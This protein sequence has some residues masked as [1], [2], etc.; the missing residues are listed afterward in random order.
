MQRFVKPKKTLL[1]ANGEKPSLA[2]L[3]H[4][5]KYASKLIA[6]DGASSWLLEHGIKP[7]LIIGDMDSAD[8]NTIRGLPLLT[9]PDQ[10]SNDLE[11]GLS[12]CHELGYSEVTVL[13]AFGLRI[14]HFL[15]NLYVLKKWARLLT[16]TLVDEYQCGFLCDNQRQLEFI[17]LA[18]N[19]ISFFPLSD[20]VGPVWS[21]GVDYPLTNEMLSMSFRI[22]TLNRICSIKATLYCQNGDLFVT[23][24]N[25]MSD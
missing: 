4:Y 14:D 15:T 19:F 3:E 23:M 24:P 18:G 20:M 12:Y 6:L 16:V 1:I 22:G 25:V 7:D 17:N 9:V 13:G 21:T 5:R 10:N 11:K 8:F 2:F